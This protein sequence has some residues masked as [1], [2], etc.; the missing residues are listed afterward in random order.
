MC[1]DATVKTL[2]IHFVKDEE[3]VFYME[4]NLLFEM[5]SLELKQLLYYYTK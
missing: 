5:Y 3:N 4:L 1:T 2:T